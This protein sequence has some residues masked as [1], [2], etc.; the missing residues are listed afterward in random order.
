MF[1]VEYNFDPWQSTRFRDQINQVRES[2]TAILDYFISL[3]P[4]TDKVKFRRTADILD[5]L[6]TQIRVKTFNS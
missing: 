3:E 1:I 4:T 5:L 6:L 2:N